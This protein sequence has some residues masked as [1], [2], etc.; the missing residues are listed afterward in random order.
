LGT[1]PDR[2]LDR[3]AACQRQAEQH[4]GAANVV[5]HLEPVRGPLRHRHLLQHPFGQLRNSFAIEPGDDMVVVDQQRRALIAQAG[6]GARG[7]T[8]Q[9]IVAG[10]VG[11]DAQTCAQVGHQRLAAE[12]AVGD[13]VAEQRCGTG[14]PAGCGRSGRNSRRPPHAPIPV[15]GSA[16]DAPVLRAA[17]SRR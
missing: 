1:A 17:T 15:S 5:V 14:Q 11:L 6:T 13:V 3:G 9:P 12:H 2:S 7:D 10:L 4:I 8:A 16:R